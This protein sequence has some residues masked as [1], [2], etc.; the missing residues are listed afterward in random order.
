MRRLQ[1]IY[2]PTS[3]TSVIQACKLHSLS[4]T[5]AIHASYLLAIYALSS[6]NH[7]SR[8]YASMMPTQTRLRLPRS[9]PYRDQ[10]C[11]ASAQMLWLTSPP[12]LIPAST[13]QTTAPETFLSLANH[14]LKQYRLADSPQ[15]LFEDAREVVSRTLH[16][17]GET[18]PDS[19]VTAMPWFTSIGLLDGATQTLVSQHNG[20][21]EIEEVTVWADNP[22]PGV[23]FGQWGFRGR[24]NLQ[25]HWN[26]G[27]Q[28]EDDIRRVMD[29]ME[30][31]ILE[32]LG[33]Q[34]RV[35]VER[36]LGEVY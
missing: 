7:R 2:N 21:I 5:S 31:A 1:R 12:P 17:S 19:E 34:L 11:W 8:N 9:S 16:P 32:G 22:G 23:V 10:G 35:E 14:L 30:T 33:V 15:W 25:M 26:E 20:G 24:L 3:T 28:S 6:P 36:G 29:L 27:F 13:F 18:P 4:I